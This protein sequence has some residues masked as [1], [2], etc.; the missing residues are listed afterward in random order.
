MWDETNGKKGSN[1]IASCIVKYFQKL[2]PLVTSVTSFSDTCGGQNSNRNIAAAMV[3]SVNNVGNLE[4]IDLKYMES[5]HSYLDA[6]SIHGR[7]EEARKH[8]R[9]YTPNEYGIVIQFAR[10]NP[11][12]YEVNHICF[13]DIQDWKSF[14]TDTLKNVTKIT[15]EGTDTTVEWLKIKWLR[16][17]RGSNTIQFKYDLTKEDFHEFN[18]T[19]RPHPKRKNKNELPDNFLKLPKVLERMKSGFLSKQPKRMTS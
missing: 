3:W 6:D 12:P 1:E 13:N 16:F 9:I 19:I 15:S 18:F 11:K 7:I 2:P 14:S 4:R 8:K 5:G 10:L 17:E